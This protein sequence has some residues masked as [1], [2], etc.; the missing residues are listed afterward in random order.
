LRLLERVAAL[1][2]RLGLGGL[3]D[4]LR[5]RALSELGDFTERVGDI[6]LTG[7]IALHSH[8]VRQLQGDEREL[9][10]GALFA[11]SIGEGAVVL[12]L[13]AYL[14]YF[15]VLAGRRGARVIA[16]EPD[17][18]TL[19]YLRRNIESNGIADR[20]R[21]V[22]R[23][24]G[25]AAGT[26]IFFLS[27]GG[28]ESTLHPN[29]THETAVTVQVTS[30]DSETEGLTVDVIKMDV[31]GAE[32]EALAGMARTLESASPDLVMFVERSAETLGRTGHTP[33]ELDRAL[34]DHGFR[35]E[36]AD[37]DEGRDYVNLVC[38]RAEATP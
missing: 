35:L 18:R 3:V 29:A 23:A 32:L 4:R 25:A 12:D 19:P 31:E 24:V 17:P 8:Y 20:V 21:I 15:T 33:E 10:T 9:A 22:E 11:E 38:R 16:F 37:R 13:G 6:T 27:Q 34:R 5:G 2:R 7:D 1:L 36:V 26:A 30:V 28:D 14:G